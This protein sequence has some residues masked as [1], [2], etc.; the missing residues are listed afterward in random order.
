M[1]RVFSIRSVNP[2][3][4]ASTYGW[5]KQHRNR[6]GQASK[7]RYQLLPCGSFRLG[8]LEVFWGAEDNPTRYIGRS[9]A[10]S[11]HMLDNRQGWAYYLGQIT[12]G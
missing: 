4:M 8:L 10:K 5:K 1:K 7:I 3:I 11:L 6:G 9:Q 12:K 2:G